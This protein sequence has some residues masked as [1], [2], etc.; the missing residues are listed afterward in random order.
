M[1]IKD[2]FVTIDQAPAI[3]KRPFL[4]YHVNLSDNSMSYRIPLYSV[5]NPQIND[6]P[7]NA[8]YLEKD[9]IVDSIL[10]G[11][12][13][14]EY[15]KDT[16]EPP[17]ERYAFH[18]YNGITYICIGFY[19]D[20]LWM[21][22][23]IQ[24]IATNQ[25]TYSMYGSKDKDGDPNPPMILSI[26]DKN[27]KADA[28]KYAR[29]SFDSIKLSM[30]KEKNLDESLINLYG[31]Q[32]LISL[33]TQIEGQL[34]D[35]FSIGKYLINKISYDKESAQ[36]EGVDY[37]NILN[38]K[39]PVKI[40][41]KSEYPYLEDK[42]IDKI[43]P[44]AIGICNGVPGVCLNGLQVYDS[45][46]TQTELT[47]YNF[48]F[49]PGWEGNPIKI[50]VKNGNRWSEVY[51]SLGNP[52][53]SGYV[54]PNPSLPEINSVTGIVKINCTQVLEGGTFAGSVKEV[55]MYAKWT[56]SMPKDAI[57]YILSLSDKDGLLAKDF[58]GEFNGL[59]KTGLYM[60]K[61]EPLFY[62]IEQ[63]QASNIIGGQLILR[64]NEL[65]FKL[66]NPNREKLFDIPEMDVINHE[67]LS[68]EL[69]DDFWY[70]SWDITYNKSLAED[71]NNE[72]HF[73]DEN[74]KNITGTIYNGKDSTVEFIRVSDRDQRF[75]TQHLQK[76]SMILRDL[77]ASF[78]HKIKNVQLPMYM[79]YL[80]LEFYDV[81][82]YA[83]KAVDTTNKIME[84]I[85]YDIK[86][87]I[88][89]ECVTIT[90]IERI[91]SP[92]WNG[93]NP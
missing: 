25:K 11:G 89:D 44:A 64:N 9:Y 12:R 78:R 80:N 57:K 39:Y 48:Q 81:V 59:A 10:I 42:Y 67:T 3:L 60:D 5:Y 4:P 51:P 33:R 38:K 15:I 71:E 36:I 40:F 26:S 14:F 91:K 55:R 66:E 75:D 58:D 50:E 65:F 21:Y 2:I 28:L 17:A 77:I 20:S 79:E 27:K 73:I 7:A 93:G 63:L 85:V 31:G 6:W 34:Q 18:I 1:I 92:N 29:F 45:V 24:V 43:Q 47:H 30:L 13:R 87:N 52:F 53:F 68:V 76:R 22:E 56:N 74:D 46:T 61:S 23:R 84:W 69:A 37:R 70:S 90:L 16:D 32:I 41:K 82:G 83:P 35:N 8:Y 62:W 72:G 54:S 49:P 19:M 86:K 88:K